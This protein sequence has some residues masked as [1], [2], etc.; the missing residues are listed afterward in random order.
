MSRDRSL[1]LWD[2]RVKRLEYLIGKFRQTTNLSSSR[3]TSPLAKV[4]V[5]SVKPTKLTLGSWTCRLAKPTYL[6]L[7]IEFKHIYPPLPDPGGC[8]KKQN[9]IRT[10]PYFLLTWKPDTSDTRHLWKQLIIYRSIRLLNF[11]TIAS[12][13]SPSNS[14]LYISPTHD[15][16]G[17]VKVACFVFCVFVVVFPLAMR[18]TSIQGTFHGTG[19]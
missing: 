16:G 7:A 17:A 5:G 19:I 13:L 10:Q 1:E 3:S 8:A 15:L 11:N 4:A 9:V 6:G 18:L 2:S 12:Y 14:Q